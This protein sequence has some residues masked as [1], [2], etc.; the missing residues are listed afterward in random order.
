MFWKQRWKRFTPN[1]EAPA[2]A[3]ACLCSP[4]A[5]LLGCRRCLFGVLAAEAL[6]AAC[7][8]YQALLAGEER[9]A[10]GADFHADLA[11]VRGAGLEIVSAGAMYLDCC[12]LWVNSWL[13]HDLDEPFLQSS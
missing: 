2:A 9:V 10:V 13:R 8:V 6:Y 3:E 5:G 11:L 1:N 7:R 4:T 12:V